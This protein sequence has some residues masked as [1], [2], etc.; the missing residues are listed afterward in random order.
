MPLFRIPL[1]ADSLHIFLPDG[2]IE[3]A[4]MRTLLETAIAAQPLAPD[5]PPGRE[6]DHR[7]ATMHAIA[8]FQPGDALEA[9]LAAQMV[10]THARVMLC[11]RLAAAPDADEAAARRHAARAASLMRCMQATLRSLQKLQA[12]RRKA[13]EQPSERAGYWFRDVS[14]PAPESLPPSPGLTR[15][16]DPVDDP[17][18]DPSACP[19]APAPGHPMQ[20]NEAPVS[21]DTLVRFAS[22]RD[23]SNR[24]AD[25]LPARAAGQPARANA[26]GSQEP[27]PAR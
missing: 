4:L 15:G 6:T 8:A 1:A 21:M 18:L 10:A 20:S 16:S 9:M 26:M 25:G 7:L 22:H 23:D 17:T 2:P 14:V 27:A 24:A 13:E 3:P 5:A 11:F 12:A 19:R